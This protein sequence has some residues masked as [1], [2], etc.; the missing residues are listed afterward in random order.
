MSI[1]SNIV[2]D[3]ADLADSNLPCLT[4]CP[5]LNNLQ[6]VMEEPALPYCVAA[7]ANS[8]RSHS[9]FTGVQIHPN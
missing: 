5:S 7:D 6:I 3:V 1:R 8:P 4:T 2:V 9:K